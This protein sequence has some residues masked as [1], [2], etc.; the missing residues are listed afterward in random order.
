MPKKKSSLDFICIGAAKSATTTLHELIKSHPELSVPSTKEAPYFSDDNVYYRGLEWY[1]Q[2]NFSGSNPNTLWGTLTPQYMIGQGDITPDTVAQRIK[3]DLPNV[4]IIVLIRHP[5]ERAFS[6]Y[7]MLLRNGH[8][9]RSFEQA[10]NDIL[11]GNTK[12]DNYEDPDSNYILCSEYGK[13]LQSYYARFPKSNI[14]VLTTDQL[15]QNPGQTLENIFSFL[16]IDTSYRPD[17]I[18]QQSRK[19]GSSPRIKFLTPGFL[20]QI[21]MVKKVWRNYIPQPIRKRAEYVINLW[22]TKPD[23][24]KLSS[25]SSVYKKLVDYF[26]GDIKLLSRL[27][28]NKITWDDW[29]K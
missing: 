24:E 3:N 28:G 18:G 8:E 9:K 22:N 1:T 14:L 16:Q 6:H 29:K 11:A 4:K 26:D 10:V 19:G 20:Y 23:N 13:I 21:P 5:I 7:R 12:L 15:K 17:N 27:T 25:S 2:A